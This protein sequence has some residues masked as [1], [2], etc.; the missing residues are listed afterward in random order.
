MGNQ[1][2][3]KS[4][5][6]AGIASLHATRA[7]ATPA[8][9]TNRSP[10]VASS[11]SPQRCDAAGREYF[12]KNPV[13]TSR[14]PLTEIQRSPLTK[15]PRSPLTRTRRKSRGQPPK[16]DAS[17][18][19]FVAILVSLGFSLRQIARDLRIDHSTISRAARRDGEFAAALARA[20]EE[21]CLHPQFGFRGWRGAWDVLQRLGKRW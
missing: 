4:E 3:A 9:E 15:R 7:A 8:V 6:D 16:L 17:R 19:K 13:F 1:L 14:T 10:A 20:K 2:S 11:L 5:L 12:T 18:K 21:R